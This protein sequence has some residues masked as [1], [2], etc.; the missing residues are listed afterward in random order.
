MICDSISFFTKVYTRAFNYICNLSAYPCT[1]KKGLVVNLYKTGDPINN[2]NYRGLTI[3]SC[4]GK[5]FNSVLN[6][7]ITKFLEKNKIIND[8][9]I[10]FRK[11]ARTSDHIFILNTLVHKYKQ[12]KNACSCALLTLGRP[13]TVFGRRLLCWNY[14]EMVLKEKCLK[15]LMLCMMVVLLEW[16]MEKPLQRCLILRQAWG[17]VMYLA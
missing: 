10:G 9:Q 6:N 2:N 4:V 1:W 16:K 11:N 14:L 7:R 5:V 13:L 17:R 3:N 12:Q 15:L 8:E